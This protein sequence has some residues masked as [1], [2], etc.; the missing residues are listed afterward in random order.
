MG[1]TTV[2]FLVPGGRAAA[3]AA[4]HWVLLAGGDMSRDVRD[5]LALLLSEMVNNAVQHGGADERERIQV[6]LSWPSRRLRVEVA[7]PG[8]RPPRIDRAGHA[9][10][11]LGPRA[12][13]QPR[14][15]LGPRERPRGRQRRLVRAD[16]SAAGTTSRRRRGAGAILAVRAAVAQL[17]RASACHAEGRGFESLQPLRPKAPLR[18]G[19][20]RFGR[21]AQ[22]R[23]D[24]SSTPLR[25]AAAS[26][27]R[28]SRRAMS[29]PAPSIRVP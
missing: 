15:P 27:N 25:S 10:G 9:R 11:R 29:A 14:R 7:R 3:T 8:H 23:S 21:V 24:A 13:G 26:S 18:R 5:S 19:F 28:S 17:A 20:L 2:S 1:V 16:R 6:R 4:R 12:R 22:S